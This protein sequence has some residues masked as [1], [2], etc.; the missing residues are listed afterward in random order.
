MNQFFPFSANFVVLLLIFSLNIRLFYFESNIYYLVP[1]ISLSAAFFFY[2]GS[3]FS[4]SAK[5]AILIPI[6]SLSMLFFN[7]D[8]KIFY[9]VPIFS[10][11]S[12]W[13][14]FCCFY[15][16]SCYFKIKNI[17]CFGLL[18]FCIKIKFSY[19]W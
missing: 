9:L 19:F 17:I 10:I 13:I 8:S 15:F 12:F 7:L 2:L 3:F 18:N 14:Y 1:T 11:T 6:F 4:I 16:K 5:L